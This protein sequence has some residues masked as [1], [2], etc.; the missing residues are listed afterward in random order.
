MT[1]DPYC[2]LYNLLGDICDQFLQTL[3][4]C[5][6]LVLKVLIIEEYNGWEKEKY[7][8][9]CIVGIEILD[10]FINKGH[11]RRWHLNIIWKEWF[12]WLF[13]KLNMEAGEMA[14][15][16]TILTTLPEDLGLISL[17]WWLRTVCFSSFKV[18]NTLSWPL[19]APYMQ[20]MP[21]YICRKK[22]FIHINIKKK[23]NI[24][25]QKKWPG[26]SCWNISCSSLLEEKQGCRNTGWH[27][28]WRQGGNKWNI[29]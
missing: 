14:L 5:L 25:S 27:R 12:I 13:K 7:I 28:R 21:R 22:N 19:W 4:S 29:F 11:L 1:T 15:R 6:T 24:P 17:P 20:L 16:L 8:H 10:N 26:G 18:F 9:V 3:I 23:L 2:P